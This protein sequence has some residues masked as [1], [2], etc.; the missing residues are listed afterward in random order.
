MADNL[1]DAF[2]KELEKFLEE[3]GTKTETGE[4]YYEVDGERLVFDGPQLLG[5]YN[6]NVGIEDA[7]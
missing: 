7:E 5:R 3:N 6:P 2:H 1:N 4:T